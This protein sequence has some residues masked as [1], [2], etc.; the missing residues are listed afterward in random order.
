M[1][2]NPPKKTPFN[3][4]DAVDSGATGFELEDSPSVEITDPFNPEEVRVTHGTPI[5]GSIVTRIKHNEINLKPGYQRKAGIWTEA[6]Q[7]RLIESLLIRIPLPAFYVDAADEDKWDIID[8]LQRLTAMKNFIIDK[9]LRLT[10]LEFLTDYN[11]YSY[12]QLP[13]HFQ[14]R[15]EEAQLVFYQLEKGTPKNIKFNIF[16]RINTGGLPLS[17]Q[18]IR[19]ALNPGAAPILLERLSKTKEFLQATAYSIRDDRMVDREI[20]LRN[21]AFLIT[22]FEDYK[23]REDLD[24]FLND[25]ME[26]INSFKKDELTNLENRFI[27]TMKASKEIFDG[28]AFRKRYSMTQ[29]Q[30]PP[31]NKPLFEAVSVNLD[32][33][34]N[35][36]INK[37]IHNKKIVQQELVKLMAYDETF[38]RSI[39]SATGKPQSVLERFSKIKDIYERHSS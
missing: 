21:L 31:I 32:C 13:R 12:D 7:S 14:R 27:N 23:T 37:I 25:A 5:V 1:S 6:A 39:T 29:T 18:E 33:F 17:S 11:G 38:L 16:R 26:K 4:S 3:H 9:S 35:S 20:I 28:F 22:S 34:S 30:R 2:N 24:T 19:H 36:Q 15:I 10:G 8:G